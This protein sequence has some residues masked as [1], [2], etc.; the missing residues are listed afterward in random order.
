MGFT[1]GKWLGNAVH[2]NRIKRRLKEIVR[3]SRV[4]AGWDLVI[5]AR[6]D[7]SAASFEELREAVVQVLD[8][9]RL[10]EPAERVGEAP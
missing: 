2:R 9:A 3:I 7:A 5:I 8:R 1:V 4:E 10:L 6:R